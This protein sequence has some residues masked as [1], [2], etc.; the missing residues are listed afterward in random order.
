MN[1]YKAESTATEAPKEL[2]I[3]S[4]PHVV[5]KRKNVQRTDVSDEAGEKVGEK[6]TFEECTQKKEEYE[7]QLAEL[8]SPTMETI[9]QELSAMQ[10]AQAETQVTLEILMEGNANV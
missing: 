4:S 10:M 3:T 7:R 6:W 9:M 8:T 5:Y 1:W 2:D